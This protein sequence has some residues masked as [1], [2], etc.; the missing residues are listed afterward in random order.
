MTP[1]GHHVAEYRFSR[2]VVR[3]ADDDCCELS[4][5]QIARNRRNAT[6]VAWE[7]I[8]RARAEGRV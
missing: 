4:P 1:E 3:I 7:I 5:E 2:C 6:S 8:R